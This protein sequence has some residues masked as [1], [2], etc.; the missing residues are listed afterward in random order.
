M[1][2]TYLECALQDEEFESFWGSVR[3]SVRNIKISHAVKRP[4]AVGLDRYE[5]PDQCFYM[6]NYVLGKVKKLH[7]SI[8]NRLGCR[9]KKNIGGGGGHPPPMALGVNL[10][11]YIYLLIY[12]LI[13]L[14][15]Y[16]LIYLFIYPLFYLSINL[17]IYISNYQFIF[18]IIHIFICLL[19]L[20][21]RRSKHKLLFLSI[22]L[23]IKG[24][25]RLKGP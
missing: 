6:S 12:P 3:P 18:L 8:S 25:G 10:S 23:S 11:P 5:G 15:I 9:L 20:N 17:L 7:S 14:F 16:L 24:G 4:Q 2:L 13:Y 21:E 1:I 22:Y 19:Y